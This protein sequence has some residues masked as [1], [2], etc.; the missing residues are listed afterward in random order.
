MKAAFPMLVTELGMVTEVRPLQPENAELPMLVNP[1]KYCSSSNDVMVVLFLNTS[2]KS[3]TAAAS[4]SLS[5]PSPLVSQF[6][7]QSAFTLASAKVMAGESSTIL[8][9][10]QYWAVSYTALQPAGTYSVAFARLVKVSDSIVRGVP[11]SA[12]TEVRF[13]I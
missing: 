8:K 13:V 10:C 1:V 2:P 9:S 11:I 7:R 6:C 4:A 3:V 5:S 12:V